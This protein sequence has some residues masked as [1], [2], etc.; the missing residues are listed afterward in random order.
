MK[1]ERERIE[2][3]GNSREKYLCLLNNSL[4]FVFSIESQSRY[5][6]EVI[7][8]DQDLRNHKEKIEEKVARVKINC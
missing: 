6:D 7:R 2:K 1:Q 8:S 5:K 3:K 4:N